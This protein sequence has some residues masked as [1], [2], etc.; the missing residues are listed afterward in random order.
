MCEEI[1]STAVESD[2]RCD[3]CAQ[4]LTALSGRCPPCMQQLGVDIKLIWDSVHA[5]AA[6]CCTLLRGML[7]WSPLVCDREGRTYPCVAHVV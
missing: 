4:V 7:L 3:H 1:E 6:C 5:A 2:D